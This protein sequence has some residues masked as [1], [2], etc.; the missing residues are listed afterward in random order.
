MYNR[1]LDTFLKVA[2]LGSFSKAANALYI[3]PSAVIQQ[4]NALEDNLG[5]SLFSR[6]PRG[7]TLTPAGELL[8]QES[9]SLIEQ[10][11]ELRKK[12]TRLQGQSCQV[13]RVGT[14][15][16]YQ[17]RAFY[18]LWNRFARHRPE[19][20]I[21]I[22]TLPDSEEENSI[23]IIEAVR[24]GREAPAGLSFFELTQTPLVCALWRDHPL[25]KKSVLGYE[26]MRG[27]TLVTVDSPYFT[28]SLRALRREAEENHVR[29][30]VTDNYDLSVFGMCA[31]KGYLLQIPLFWRDINPQLVSVPC[32]WNYT[33][34]YGFYYRDTSPLAVEFINFVKEE[35]ESPDFALNL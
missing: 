25:A 14:A 28:D 11:D 9:P 23:D 35:M 34:P 7:T 21:S 32:D 24:F 6:T 10:C 5:V 3:T 27:Q 16:L 22:H 30:M 33:L 2:E 20:Q 13:I 31:A 15:L 8:R 18:D 26:D 17:C 4:I 1:Q 29:V 19:L 12:L